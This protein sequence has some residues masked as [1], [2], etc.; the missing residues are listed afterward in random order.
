MHIVKQL[1]A[2]PGVIAAGE[3]AY[4]G[5]RYSYQ[6]ALTDEFARMASILCR[7]NTLSVNMQS[8]MLDSFAE[9]SGLR[10]VQ[11]W[12]VR[13]AQVTVCAIGNYFSFIEN[14]DEL[15]NDVMTIMRAKVGDVQD[16]LLVN[17]YARL[18]GDT[19]EALY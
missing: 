13:G 17:L 5:D 9:N 6:G 11:G 8:E 16:D 18:G 2:I 19:R 10:P 4:R 7:A 14:R 12:S 1:M 3:Y 15:L